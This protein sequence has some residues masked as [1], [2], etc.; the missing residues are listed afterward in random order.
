MHDQFEHPFPLARRYRSRV[1]P[2]VGV[3][4]VSLILPTALAVEARS[5]ASAFSLR[6]TASTRSS[7]KSVRMRPTTGPHLW[8][9]DGP[10]ALKP[11]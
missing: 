8:L 5:R 9:A 6:L 10:Q 11:G 2:I 1:L 7:A 3:F 4:V